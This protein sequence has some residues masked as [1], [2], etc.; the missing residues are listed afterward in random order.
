MCNFHESVAARVATDPVT[1]KIDA[2]H[3]AIIR[4]ALSRYWA[5]AYVDGADQVDGYNFYPLATKRQQAAFERSGLRQPLTEIEAAEEEGVNY[6]R[7]RLCALSAKY[8][9]S[10]AALKLPAAFAREAFIDL[11]ID[12]FYEGVPRDGLSLV[13]SVTL[14]QLRPLHK[15]VKAIHAD[16][17]CSQTLEKLVQGKI[18][19]LYIQAPEKTQPQVM[20]LYESL[21]APVKSAASAISKFGGNILLGGFGGLV[22]H[23]MHYAAVLG[24]GIAAGTAST[25]NFAM[26]GMFL[27]ASYAGWHEIFGGKYRGPREKTSALAVQAAMTFAIAVGVQQAMPENHSHGN[28]AA[29][30]ESMPP[31]LKQAFDERANAT[32]AALPNDL[33]TRLDQAARKEGVPASVYLLICDGAD[34]LAQ[35]INK[36]LASRITSPKPK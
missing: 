17:E 14:P 36:H 5:S 15:I 8:D 19:T 11:A 32:Y 7:E 13:D 28:R 20:H 34:P 23:G 16:P 35:E 4:V 10:P 9:L 25:M 6:L 18:A 22:G 33:R 31:K 24:A 12:C 30:Y 21:P 2:G 26:S 29:F 27:L 1:G 3:K